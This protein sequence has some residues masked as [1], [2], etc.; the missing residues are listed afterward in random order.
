RPAFPF[1]M[2][3]DPEVIEVFAADSTDPGRPESTLKTADILSVYEP[4]F[5]N[6]PIYLRYLV[7]LVETWLNDLAFHWKSDQ[8]P[9]LGELAAIG[10][11][12][13]LEGG[14]TTHE[15]TLYGDPLRRDQF[16]DDDR[17]GAGHQRG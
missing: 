12:P 9:G 1:G 17:Q 2:Y 7:A 10:L 5:R 3:V 13:L 8:P 16:R 15:V 4:D 11:A 6:K 14:G